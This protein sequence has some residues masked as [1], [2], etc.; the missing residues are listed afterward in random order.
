[1]RGDADCFHQRTISTSNAFFFEPEFQQTAG[2]VF[3][4]YR[5]AYGNTQPFPNPDNANTTESNTSINYPTF[6]ADRARVVGGAD[7]AAAQ[8]SFAN[9]FISRPEFTSR[10]ASGLTGPQFVDA[11]LARIQADDGVDLKSQR[12]TLIDQYNNAGGG[13]AGRGQVLYR[14]ADDTPQNPIRT[15]LSLTPSIIGSLP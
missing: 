2:F 4:A 10:Y 6:V 7:L 12:Q 15:R 3:R 14:L 9:V 1:M 11:L 8:L 13:N 5:A